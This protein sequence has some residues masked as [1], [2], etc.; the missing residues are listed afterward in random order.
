MESEHLKKTKWIEDAVK[1]AKI[2]VEIVFGGRMWKNEEKRKWVEH[3]KERAWYL[4]GTP[5]KGF[6]VID[7]GTEGIVPEGMICLDNDILTVESIGVDSNIIKEFVYPVNPEKTYAEWYHNFYKREDLDMSVLS[8]L[9]EN[10]NK[11]KDAVSLV[12]DTIF[13]DIEE[14]PKKELSELREEWE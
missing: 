6:V 13:S 14:K 11:V 9:N 10:P 5:P 12:I 2:T 8:M 1:Y 4:D 3:I 7:D